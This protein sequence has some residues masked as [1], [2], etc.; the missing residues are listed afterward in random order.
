MFPVLCISQDRGS[1]DFIARE[2]NQERSMM[3]LST[4]LRVVASDIS[5]YP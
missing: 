3:L 5:L 1:Y 2:E 4:Y